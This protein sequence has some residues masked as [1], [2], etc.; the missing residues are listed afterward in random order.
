MSRAIKMGGASG[1]SGSDDVTA[2]K[3]QLLE[4]YTAITK[5]SDDEPGAGTMKHLTNR[6]TV[7]HET[8]NGTKVL[9]GDAAFMV[10]NSDGVQRAEIRYNGSDGYVTPNTLFAIPAGTMATAGGMTAA[11]VLAG[12]S[13]FGISGTATNDATATASQILTG[14]T[15]Y[16]KGSK[17]TG[18]M[19]NQ[20]A[21]SQSLGINGTY[22]IPPGYHNGSGRL[23]QSIATKG[24]ATYTPG[25]AAQTIAAGQYLS[26]AQTIAP[27]PSGWYNAVQQA[28]FDYGT[29]GVAASTGAFYTTSTAGWSTASASTPTTIQGSG[30][31]RV[32]ASATDGQYIIFRAAFPVALKYIRVTWQ[33]ATATP[34]YVR[35]YAI[36]PTTLTTVSLVNGNTVTGG[37]LC[38]T[39]LNLSAGINTLSDF[40]ALG[41]TLSYRGGYYGILKVE[42]S[43]TAYA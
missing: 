23:T 40:W 42:L 41:L 24:A 29:Y 5:D 39:N 28:V 20:G 35:A 10:K 4:N 22:T 38:T 27:I 25:T 16:V 19:A 21:V 13:A 3:A 1:G 14:T 8:A 18:A 17:I 2:A 33:I 9:V 26:G 32:G 7:T 37:P 15:A 34:V 43:P 6:A 30:A 11:K 31:L 12:Q 36:N